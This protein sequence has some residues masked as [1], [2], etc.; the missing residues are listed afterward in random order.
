MG[1]N[2][3]SSSRAVAD[4]L[5]DFIGERVHS[6]REDKPYSAIVIGVVR[7][8]GRDVHGFGEVTLDDAK[9]PPDGTTL[10]EIGSITKV[11]TATLLAQMVEDGKMSLDDAVSKHLPEALHP[12]TFED[13]KI[14]LLNLAT[15]RSSL[16]IQPPLIGLF[17]LASGAPTNPYSRYTEKNLAR[18]L[19]QIKLSKPIGEKFA[20]SN[21]GVGLLG[22]ALVHAA[23]TQ[24]Y[25]QLVVKRICKP[26]DMEDTR[27]H[28]NEG[29]ERRFAQGHSAAGAPVSR[30]DFASLQGAGALRSTMD[31]MLKF[32]SANLGLTESTLGSA[33]KFA[34]IRRAAANSD[35][36]S[37]G[38]CWLRLRNEESDEAILFHNGGTGG[39]RSFVGLSPSQRFG[40]VVLSNS[41]HSVDPLGFAILKQ[42]AADEGGE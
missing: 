19:T 35:S 7:P 10:F 32:A 29:L 27:I 2:V 15:H 3:A 42:L 5:S 37:I 28:L 12:P 1:S 22:H 13:Q 21:L 11:F 4:E 6:F 9:Q 41:T 17:A 36:L 31:D 23:D 30:W 33:F 40:I 14:T 26:L 38:L 20:Y 39:F 34:H 24:R 8:D 18:T 16:P 25:E